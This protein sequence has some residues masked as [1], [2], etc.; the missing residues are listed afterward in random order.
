MLNPDCKKTSQKEKCSPQCFRN[1]TSL[2]QDK[3]FSMMLMIK[4]VN[5]SDLTKSIIEI[6]IE[7]FSFQPCLIRKLLPSDILCSQIYKYLE[8]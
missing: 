3:N 8:T 1:L 4:Q 6:G 7:M 5:M 2:S